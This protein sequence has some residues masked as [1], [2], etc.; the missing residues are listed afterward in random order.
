MGTQLPP[1]MG[2]APPPNFRPISIVAQQTWAGN[3]GAVS[4]Q[5][6]THVYCG[7]MAGWT[8]MPLAMEVALGLGDCVSWGS[9]S[10]QKKGHSP[11][12]FLVMDVYCD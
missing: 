6:P 5:F 8:K 10:P 4:P 9:S 12:Q 2:T 11:T 7:Q 1:K 3:W